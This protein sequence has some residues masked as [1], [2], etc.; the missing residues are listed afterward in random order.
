MPVPAPSRPR[1]LRVA[2]SAAAVVGALAACAPADSGSTTTTPQAS[3]SASPSASA[4]AACA[5]DQLQLQK[6]GTLTIG[7]DK[8]AYAPWFVDDDPT[9]GKGFESA[10]AYAVAEKLGFAK[11]D[12]EWTVAS[13]NS[14]LAPGPKN[15]DFDVNQV[16]ITEDRR[17]N[18][19][20]SSGYY[21]VTQAVVTAKGSKIAG[22]KSIAD[23]K[24]AK[25][26]AQVGTTSYQTITDVIQPSAKPAVFDKNDDAKLALDN[27]QVDGIVVDL[28]TALYLAAAEIKDGIVVG[29]FE[30][31]GGTPEQFGLVLDKGSPLTACVSKAVDA[32]RSD[33]TLDQI[34]QEW[35]TGD[36][37]APVLK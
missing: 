11:D 35:L 28:P 19:D 15:F 31:A 33:G 16:S 13:F 36:A 17:K 21:D 34:E 37:G 6:P 22:A 1:R 23:L 32:L 30:N 9:N 12:V 5:K 20:F 27:G 14:V 18:I 3:G 2:V 25:L 8:P 29:Q 7:T 24:D 26:G 4:S 10:V